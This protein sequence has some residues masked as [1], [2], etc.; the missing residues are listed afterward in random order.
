MQLPCN[1]R[2]KEAGPTK[3]GT[4][5]SKSKYSNSNL[6]MTTREFADMVID[7]LDEQN[8]FKKDDVAHPYDIAISFTTVGETIGKAM[9]WAIRQ[10]ARLNHNISYA[11]T[12]TEHTAAKKE[13]VMKT[14]NL[15]KNALP[16]DDEIAPALLEDGEPLIDDDGLGYN[17]WRSKKGYM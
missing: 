4:I 12:T 14:G 8:Y 6:Y 2:P 10:E 13:S 7:A 5:M 16:I 9:E 15:R 1:Y 3:K 11:A 17:E